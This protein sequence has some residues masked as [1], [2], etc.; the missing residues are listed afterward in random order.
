MQQTTSEGLI[1]HSSPTRPAA[2]S[3]LQPSQAV[4][5][6]FV[7]ILRKTRSHFRKKKQNK[8]K[9]QSPLFFFFSASLQRG[10]SL[11][12][13]FKRG[14]CTVGQTPAGLPTLKN[15]SPTFSALFTA[16]GN[17]FVIFFFLSVSIKLSTQVALIFLFVC[18]FCPFFCSS[19]NFFALGLEEPFQGTKNQK[20]CLM[21]A[22][23]L[24]HTYRVVFLLFLGIGIF[25]QGR[26]W[27]GSGM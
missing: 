27:V 7:A 24:H 1:S 25:H 11:F 21:C 26:G 15:K 4:S 17:V 16:E 6:P 19:F 22:D 12:R 2:E 18:C 14:F 5:S 13:D 3:E 10:R 23:V 9:H 20:C 8:K